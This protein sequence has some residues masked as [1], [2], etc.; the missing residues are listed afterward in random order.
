MSSLTKRTTS[1]INTLGE[2]RSWFISSALFQRADPS[3]WLQGPCVWFR[4]TIFILS[5][6]FSVFLKKRWI[7]ASYF[8]PRFGSHLCGTYIEVSH[9][10]IFNYTSLQSCEKNVGQTSSTMF[11][12]L[13]DRH[14]KRD[15][16]ETSLMC[17]CVCVYF[18]RRGISGYQSLVPF[19]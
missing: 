4:S 2:R 15:R 14:G 1:E 8:K 17:V 6:H 3:L 12:F 9:L 5:P 16:W 13:A 11:L 7:I 10:I 19:N 18:P